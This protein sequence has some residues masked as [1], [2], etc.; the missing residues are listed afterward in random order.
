MR[1]RDENRQIRFTRIINR[2]MSIHPSSQTREITWP[3]KRT[4]AIS[5]KKGPDPCFGPC[6]T[7]R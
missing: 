3:R 5:I 4:N 1:H 2:K 7:E 6:Q